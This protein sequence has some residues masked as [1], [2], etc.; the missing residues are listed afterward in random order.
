M[1][2]PY[3][4]HRRDCSSWKQGAEDPLHPLDQTRDGHAYL[5]CDPS[6][7]SIRRRVLVEN[8]QRGLISK[9]NACLNGNRNDGA[10]GCTDGLPNRASSRLGT[11]TEQ[12]LIWHILNLD[13]EG[14]E[15][16]RLVTNALKQ[17]QCLLV[18]RDP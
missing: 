8:D 3:M 16:I 11:H 14:Q 15:G 7:F 17:E 12:R 6:D 5:E 18:S 10:E 2:R 4:D 1:V 9:V 13:L